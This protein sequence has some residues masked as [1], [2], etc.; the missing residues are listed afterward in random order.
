MECVRRK[1]A[2]VLEYKPHALDE[3]Q[4]HLHAG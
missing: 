2:G 1:R 4:T 3:L